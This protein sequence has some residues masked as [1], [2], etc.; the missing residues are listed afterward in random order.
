[1][2]RH[3]RFPNPY[4]HGPKLGFRTLNGLWAG[5]EEVA[6]PASTNPA[7]LARTVTVIV[8]FFQELRNRERLRCVQREDA[9]LPSIAKDLEAL[10][11]LVVVA[12]AV[13]GKTQ[14]GAYERTLRYFGISLVNS[15][16]AVAILC[17]AGHG[18]DAVKIARS[19][20]ETHVTFRYLL[21]RPQE[22]KDF[23]DFDAAAPYKRLQYYKSNLPGLYA[24]FPAEKINAV[25][26][27]AVKKMF[28]DSTGKIR[29]RRSRHSLAEMARVAGLA[30][31]YDLFYR[32]ASSLHH[33][34]PMGLAM[35]VDGATLEIQPGPTER[36][37]G[38]ALRMA[39]WTLHEALC[40]YSKLIG[41]DYSDALHRI[42][43]LLS[44]VVEFKG[45]VLGSLAQAFPL[46]SE[47]D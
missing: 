7:W 17:N 34:D 25:N 33:A 30:E 35:L 13:L 24:S 5:Q 41:V 22:L 42:G 26:Y 46:A 37:I 32:H 10:W 43:E 27:R 28:V 1:M 21:R 3:L 45:S 44:G 20:F 19:M 31:M 4:F 23:L 38:I 9:K 18:A 16:V 29:K 47:S 6:Q 15:S 14:T 36:H 39:T 8:A 12:Q 40:E 2:V 11:E